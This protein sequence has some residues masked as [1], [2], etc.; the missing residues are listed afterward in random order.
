[1]FTR[2][3]G[4]LARTL[5]EQDLSVAEVAALYLLDERGRLRIG[6]VAEALGRSAPAASRM[7]D[8][9]VRAGFVTREED[10]NDRRARLLALAPA[11]AAFIDRA[12]V[13]RVRTI[14]ETL[15]SLPKEVLVPLFQAITRKADSKE[16][17]H[18]TRRVRS[19]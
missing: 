13:E 7:V 18:G 14:E 19:K 4:A 5:V 2:I 9:L 8:G 6:D 11:G 3:I 15:G 16:D 10:P 17:S 12:G 1:M